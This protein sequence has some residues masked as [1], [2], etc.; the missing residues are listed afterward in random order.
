VSK[1]E[2]ANILAA[3]Q[4]VYSTKFTSEKSK[5]YFENLNDLDYTTC[6]KAVKKLIQTSEYPPTVASIRKSYLSIINGDQ[7]STEEVL[8]L[9]NKV[10]QNFGRYRIA[11]GME[12]IKQ[13]N[14]TAWRIL[15]AIGYNNYCNCD[16]S[17]TAHLINKMT[18]EIAIKNNENLA[19]ET[20]F[21]KEIGQIRKQA[22]L[23]NGY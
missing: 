9:Y 10:V 13:E 6:Q 11:E 15:K 5:L 7:S 22:M 20:Q 4:E 17:V 21:A 3:I 1:N 12:W 16:P 19:L 14:E 8:G 23:M 2:F 18:K